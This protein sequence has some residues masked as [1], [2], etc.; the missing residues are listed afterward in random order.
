MWW[1]N[2]APGLLDLIENATVAEMRLL[3]LLPA[4]KGFVNAE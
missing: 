2:L 4:A 3:R 1:S